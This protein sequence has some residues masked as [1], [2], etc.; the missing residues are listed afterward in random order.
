MNVPFDTTPNSGLMGRRSIFHL[1]S[2]MALGTGA[3]VAGSTKANASAPSSL[4]INPQ[5]TAETDTLLAA[6]ELPPQPIRVP[7]LSISDMWPS[8]QNDYAIAWAQG[9]IA[10]GV[11]QSGST[12]KSTDGGKSWTF[13][14]SSPIRPAHRG[15]WLRLS[16]GNH[17]TILNSSPLQIGRSTNDGATFSSVKTLAPNELTLTAQSWCQDALNGHIYLGVY[18]TTDTFTSINVYRSIDDGATWTAWYAFPGIASSNPR[19][20]RHI[21]GVQYDPFSR[22]VY[23]MAGDNEDA[24]GIYRVTADAS[25]IEKVVTKE[26]AGHNARAIGLMF[27]PEFL[28]W[29]CDSQPLGY[30]VRMARSEIGQVSPSVERVYQLNSSG[31]GSIC[32]SRDM[33]EWICFSSGES[34]PATPIDRN[35]HAYFVG[36]NGASVYELGAM[37]SQSASR[38]PVFHPIGQASLHDG[39]SMWIQTKDFF[40]EAFFRA[41]L[42]RSSGQIPRPQP[43][44]RV[45][46]WETCS[47]GLVTIAPGSNT[48]T[49]F[50]RAR[51]PISTRTLYIHDAEIR[52]VSGAGTPPRLQVVRIDTGAILMDT[53]G[54]IRV[55]SARREADEFVIRVAGLPSDIDIE[56]RIVGRD[57]ANSFSGT[58]RVT[59]G[60]GF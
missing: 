33:T 52:T 54:S 29:A 19:R 23:F 44:P 20:I 17:I 59:F 27:F 10:Y 58:A 30:L 41:S 21:H 39:E 7:V 14:G 47:S 1:G 37:A 6:G 34:S 8:A 36:D 57:P 40:P 50:M 55:G 31:W 13:L 2:A 49:P 16:S 24:A 45:Y 11:S 51:V 4:R 15:M 9:D 32:A 18:Q 22:R 46:A 38:T 53:S 60:F 5:P 43:R 25:T 28:V 35:A 26:T 42:S 48:I 12:H 3:A 56:F